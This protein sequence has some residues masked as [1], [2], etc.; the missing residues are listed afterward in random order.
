V[1]RRELRLQLVAHLG[2]C[3]QIVALTGEE[4]GDRNLIILVRLDAELA[5]MMPV[6]N[7]RFV[8]LLHSE[9]QR[10]VFRMTVADVAHQSMKNAI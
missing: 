3:L 2:I 9:R 6:G 5:A 7:Q 10:Q 4:S 8:K 1:K